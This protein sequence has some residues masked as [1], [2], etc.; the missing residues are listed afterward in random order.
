M[1]FWNSSPVE[2]ALGIW[3][4]RGSWRGCRAGMR[5]LYRA[6]GG[7]DQRWGRLSMIS[8][9]K[10]WALRRREASR[11]WSYCYKEHDGYS[12]KNRPS[13]SPDEHV[14]VSSRSLGSVTKACRGAGQVKSVLSRDVPHMTAAWFNTARR[15][16]HVPPS[17]DSDRNYWPQLIARYDWSILSRSKQTMVLAPKP[18]S[19]N[20]ASRKAADSIGQLWEP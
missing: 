6:S 11:K 20:H 9:G 15:I 18:I 2:S 12:K 16:A 17:I 5:V 4:E 10:D 14:C 3:A 8:Y 7:G 13:I 1:V 19:I